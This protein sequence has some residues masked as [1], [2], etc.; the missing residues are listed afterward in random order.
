MLTESLI[1]FTTP[2][3]GSTLLCDWLRVFLPGHF[4]ALEHERNDKFNKV[5]PA[6][7]NFLKLDDYEKLSTHEKLIR[8]E[9]HQKIVVK[10]FPSDINLLPLLKRYKVILLDRKDIKKQSLSHFI[11]YKTNQ[12]NSA[13]T[14]YSSN[15]TFGDVDRS[16]LIE[17]LKSVKMF[18]AAKSRISSQVI[19]EL[20]YEDFENDLNNLFVSLQPVLGLTE[21][22]RELIPNNYVKQNIDHESKIANI[23]LF[24][25]LWEK[26]K[27]I[28]GRF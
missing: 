16:L 1:V 26:Y 24:D 11:A 13:E 14:N 3:S 27:H 17:H 18:D 6:V 21:E 2:R 20:N 7:A 12:W 5:W 25:E 15:L 23:E 9:N 28:S 22:H 4:H 19:L 8:I 10:I